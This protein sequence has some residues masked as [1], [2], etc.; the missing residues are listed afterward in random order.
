MTNHLQLKPTSFNKII[1]IITLKILESS[2]TVIFI[3]KSFKP[4]LI[5]YIPTYIHTYIYVHM[6]FPTE[7]D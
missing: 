5:I 6:T 2:C 7:C 4:C 3:Y 1:I